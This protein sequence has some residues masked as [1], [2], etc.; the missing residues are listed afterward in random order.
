MHKKIS[1]ASCL[2]SYSALK[3]LPCPDADIEAAEARTLETA[4]PLIGQVKSS[5]P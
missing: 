3:H 1:E 4:A 2:S 5:L